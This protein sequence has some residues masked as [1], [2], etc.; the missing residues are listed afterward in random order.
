LSAGQPI[1]AQNKLT[2]PGELYPYLH[3]NHTN[4]T[5]TRFDFGKKSVRPRVV[6]PGQTISGGLSVWNCRPVAEVV[7]RVVNP[8]RRW[9][10]GVGGGKKRSLGFQ[11]PVS[12]TPG[13]CELV[14]NQRNELQKKFGEL[15]GTGACSFSK[16]CHVLWQSSPRRASAGN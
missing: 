5:G 16:T 15:S 14:E 12:K 11:F 1:K 3:H 13:G 9:G 7:W 6:M 4:M 2:E 8:A 10:R